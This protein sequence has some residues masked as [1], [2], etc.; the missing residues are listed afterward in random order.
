MAIAYEDL[1]DLA[2]VEVDSHLRAVCDLVQINPNNVDALLDAL[3]T[4]I[5]IEQEN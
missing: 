3:D 2:Q 1:D 5:Q 4:A